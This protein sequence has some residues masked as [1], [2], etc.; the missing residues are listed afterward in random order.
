MFGWRRLSGAIGGRVVLQ[1]SEEQRMLLV[2]PMVPWGPIPTAQD[3]DGVY[4]YESFCET[5][6]RPV[7]K[8]YRFVILENAFMHQRYARTRLWKRIRQALDIR[9]PDPPNWLGEDDLFEF[10]AYREYQEEA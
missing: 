10:G 6:R 1:V 3:P 7:L 2:H 4:P 5:S 8:R 9:E